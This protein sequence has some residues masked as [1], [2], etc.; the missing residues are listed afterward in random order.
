MSYLLDTNVISEI[1]KPDPNA[2]V[3]AWFAGVSSGELF[4][5]ALVVGEVRQGVERLRGR[6]PRRASQLNV[7]LTR[8]KDE[9]A[10]RIVAVSTEVAETWGRMNAVRPIPVVDGLLAATALVNGLTLVTRNTVDV[11]GS[12]VAV[13]NPFAEELE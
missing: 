9:Y 10:D 7:W 6:D 1:R 2:G 4:L 3:A 5:S 11:E 12:G 8:L 13:L